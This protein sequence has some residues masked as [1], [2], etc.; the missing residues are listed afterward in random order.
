MTE[1]YL[2]PGRT[3]VAGHPGTRTRADANSPRKTGVPAGTPLPTRS[4]RLLNIP[5]T[6]CRAWESEPRTP[7][8]AGAVGWP[9]TAETWGR[10]VPSS[11]T[12]PVPPPNTPPKAPVRPLLPQSSLPSF[13]FL[14]LARGRP[15]A[16]L[17]CGEA[18]RQ[19][20]H[21][22]YNGQQERRPQWA[23]SIH[24]CAVSRG[25]TARR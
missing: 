3:I 4:R 12:V 16:K 17:L 22:A 10:A 25:G 13:V 6:R 11:P 19:S 14:T 21:G 18:G 7:L 1:E 24:F 15:R 20:L 2:R 9:R 23:F 5:P 8:G